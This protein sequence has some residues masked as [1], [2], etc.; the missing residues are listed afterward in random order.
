MEGDNVSGRA[1]PSFIELDRSA[2]TG[3][4]TLL[5]EMLN[6][7]SLVSKDCD[8][9]S[10]VKCFLGAALMCPGPS[11]FSLQ[12]VVTYASASSDRDPQSIKLPL[13]WLSVRSLSI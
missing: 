8:M 13:K 11:H 10:A 2:T 7:A 9:S 5:L 1:S 6:A 12:R 4:A 3:V